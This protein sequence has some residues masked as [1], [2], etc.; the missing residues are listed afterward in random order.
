M[1]IGGVASGYFR[2]LDG[3][4]ITPKA[5]RDA[6]P[7]FMASRGPTGEQGGPIRLHHDFWTHFLKR[8]I[9][10]LNLSDDKQL[11]MVAAIA[12]PLGRVTKMWVD[13]G[14]K[15]HYEGYL[16]NKHPIARVVWQL[17]KEGLI[18]LGVSLGGKIVNT[19][20]GGRDALGQPCTLITEIRIDELS[21]TDNPALRLCHGE[22]SSNGAYIQAL[23]KSAGRALQP[24]KPVKIPPLSKPIRI[25]REIMETRLRKDANEANRLP[26]PSLLHSATQGGTTQ[27]KMHFRVSPDKATTH[28]KA[29]MAH[30]VKHGFESSGFYN[31]GSGHVTYI[32]K[33]TKGGWSNF[34]KSA[35]MG[36]AQAFNSGDWGGYQT[37]LDTPIADMTPTKKRTG[38]KRIEMDE[39]QPA[40]GTATPDKQKSDKPTSSRTL[41]TDVWGL[42]LGAFVRKLGKC[43][44]MSKGEFSDPGVLKFFA[45]GSKGMSSLV[46]DPPAPMVNMIRLL[47]EI[48]KFAQ[49]LPH[50]DDY[51]AKGTLEAMQG[52]L[53]KALGEFVEK[54][55]TELMGKPFRPPNGVSIADQDIMFPQQYITY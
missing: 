2:D 5:V 12:L 6:I 21:I 19:E 13:A 33:P 53:K 35:D 54:I 8:A 36:S 28:A 39:S 1:K 15:T 7:E 29:F 16:S 14:G 24:P 22:D 41:K 50:M 32:I 55:P 31:H 3:E 26:H 9:S 43:A 46:D 34:K 45:D 10:A 23:S 11:E 40:T 48:A 20:A 37:G 25:P 51:Q 30:A 49:A 42:S 17:L 27:G 38:S 52:D 18:Q 47:G 4:A 44:C